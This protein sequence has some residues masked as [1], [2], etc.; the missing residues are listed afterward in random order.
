MLLKNDRKKFIEMYKNKITD[1]STLNEKIFE[2]YKTEDLEKTGLDICNCIKLSEVTPEFLEKIWSSIKDINKGT[3]LANIISENK[4]FSS[5][6]TTKFLISKIKDF[7]VSNNISRMFRRIKQYPSDKENIFQFDEKDLIKIY[8]C[9]KENKISNEEM[10]QSQKN[11]TFILEEENVNILCIQ[12]IVY[13]QELDTEFLLKFLEKYSTRLSNDDWQTLASKCKINDEIMKKYSGMFSKLNLTDNK[14]INEKFINKYLK[15]EINNLRCQKV[16]KKF[17]EENISKVNLSL[18]FNNINNEKDYEYFI[19]L[20]LSKTKSSSVEE[21]LKN[22]LNFVLS[23][24]NVDFNFYKKMLEKYNVDVDNP[25]NLIIYM[26]ENTEP[27]YNDVIE[28]FLNSMSK[29]L[30]SGIMTEYMLDRIEHLN[31]FVNI[32]DDLIT[33]Y[34]KVL[35]YENSDY[36]NNLYELLS[37][38]KISPNLKTKFFTKTSNEDFVTDYLEKYKKCLSY[39]ILNKRELKSLNELS[40]MKKDE[41]KKFEHLL[42]MNFNYFSTLTNNELMK[43]IKKI[44]YNTKNQS[45]FHLFMFMESNPNEMILK[46]EVDFGLSIF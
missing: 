37:N 24:N 10:F 9:T 14:N 20:I 36:K 15:E 31:G 44:D 45:I 43:M 29:G 41:I 19:D 6:E 39:Q 35:S 25:S 8:K 16:S 46:K 33:K 42:L 28:K 40:K 26:N 32:P 22:T 3:V 34:I 1:F 4:K 12:K 17:L 27:K 18:I 13:N 23:N 21:L 2:I 30:E 5:E 38:Q 7:S 11:I